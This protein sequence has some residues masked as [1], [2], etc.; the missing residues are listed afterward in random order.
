MKIRAAKL[1]DWKFIKPIY[2]EGIETKNATFKTVCSIPEAAEWFNSKI[3][4]SVFVYEEHN[5]I[6]GWSCLTPVSDTCA[7]SGVAEVSVYVN[8][9]A[10][11]KG[12]GGK[13]LS[14]L[15]DFAE[16]N[17]LWT[18]QAGIFPENIGSIRL[19]EKFGFRA[20]GTREK[21]GKLDDIW[22]DTVILERRS[23]TIF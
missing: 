23:K 18:L 2:I 22:R 4:G 6:L 10:Q 8:S 9:S 11:G 19:H 5:R 12:V 15:I 14:Q 16:H 17:N 13:L 1:D 21:I 20:I 3:E 7:Y